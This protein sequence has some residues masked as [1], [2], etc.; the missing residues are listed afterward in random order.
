MMRCLPGMYDIKLIDMQTQVRVHQHH[1]DRALSRRR[2]P[3]GELLPRARGRR[4][5]A[6]HRH[7]P[8][9]A[10]QEEPDLRRRRCR[11]RPRSAPPMTAA[12]SPPWSTR[13]WRSPTTTAS[14]RARRNRRR[15]A[16]CAVSASA[17]CWST[18]AARRSKARRWRSPAASKMTFTMN[19][20]STGQ[21][22]ATI[23]PRMVA[24]RLGI[25]AEQVGHA[26]GD[27][28]H[29]IA[30]YASV[31][32]RTAMTAGHA[33]VKTLE[34]M[35]AKGKKVAAHCA[36]GRRRRHRIQERRLQRGRH[37]PPACRCSTS[38][39]APRR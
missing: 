32:S 5:G 20:Q 25:K 18:P 17:S 36:G 8:D 26:H 14:R 19:V 15:R 27:S 22:H 21:S 37:R 38:P 16:C 3:G 7:R 34:A 39:P 24:E 12:T 23:F 2:P 9:Q 30:G 6:R 31:G 33:M 35:L 4:G 28:A 11:T 13:A 10:A 1:A 29:E